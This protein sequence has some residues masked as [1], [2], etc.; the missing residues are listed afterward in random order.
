[1]Q[2]GAPSAPRNRGARSIGLHIDAVGE[3]RIPAQIRDSQAFRAAGR[4]QSAVHRAPPPTQHTPAPAPRPH[5]VPGASGNP[6]APFLIPGEERHHSPA[7][8]A[9]RS[10]PATPAPGRTRAKEAVGRSPSQ[11]PRAIPGPLGAPE[12]WVMRERLQGVGP[13]SPRSGRFPIWAMRATP[14]ASAA[15]GSPMGCGDGFLGL[16]PAAAKRS[17]VGA[18]TTPPGGRRI[19]AGSGWDVGVGYGFVPW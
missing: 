7:Q 18:L 16:A 4:A 2:P 11:D 5:P 8:V 10:A 9:P 14:Q 13:P 1:M 19:A 12:R 6:P 3:A 17:S 15:A